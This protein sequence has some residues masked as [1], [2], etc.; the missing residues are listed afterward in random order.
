M[1][2]GHLHVPDM[3]GIGAILADIFECDALI[4]EGLNPNASIG[5]MQ[6]SLLDG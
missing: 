4:G 5:Y 2:I 6:T 3:K 1:P